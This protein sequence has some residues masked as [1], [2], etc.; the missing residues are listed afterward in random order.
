[1]RVIQN[2]ATGRGRRP[3]RD[4]TFR[5]FR[6]ISALLTYLRGDFLAARLDRQVW[7]HTKD[8]RR[9]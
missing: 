5:L 2:V 4:Q 8:A 7:H 6:R 1:V 9:M 3:I